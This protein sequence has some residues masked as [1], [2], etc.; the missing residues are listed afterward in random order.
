MIKTDTYNLKDNI[1]TGYS[2]EVEVTIDNAHEEI[3][4]YYGTPPSGTIV[5]YVGNDGVSVLRT[6]DLGQAT[7]AWAR[8]AVPAIISELRILA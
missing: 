5:V 1:P 7:E 2:G 4:G 6:V 8:H 3:G